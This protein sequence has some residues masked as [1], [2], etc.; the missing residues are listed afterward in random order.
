MPIPK[1]PEDFEISQEDWEAFCRDIEDYMML[2]EACEMEQEVP[3]EEIR[4]EWRVFGRVQ[5]N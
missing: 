2:Q 4:K 3:E 5:D 1:K